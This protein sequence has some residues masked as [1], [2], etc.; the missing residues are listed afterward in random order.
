MSLITRDQ[1]YIVGLENKGKWESEKTYNIYTV[2]LFWG[3]WNY[4]SYYMYLL[5]PNC[6]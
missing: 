1:E 3:S 5:N 6:F 4:L 2:G